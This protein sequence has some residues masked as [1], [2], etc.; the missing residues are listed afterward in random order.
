MNNF[1]FSRILKLKFWLRRYQFIG[2]DKFGNMY[3]E[4]NTLTLKRRYV[5]Y[6]GIVEASKVP[7]LWNSWLHYTRE[8]PPKFKEG[9]IYKWQRDYQPNLTGTEYAYYP[10]PQKKTF[11]IGY[12][13][14]NPDA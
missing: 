10:E 8:T 5:I 3:Y 11:S 2:Q 7:P 12:R 4:K 9:N 13:P 6:K 14:W 1:L